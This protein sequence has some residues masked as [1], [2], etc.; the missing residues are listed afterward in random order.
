MKIINNEL[1]FSVSDIVRHFRS[2][3]SAWA[4][5][6]NL[7]QPGTVYVENDMI[8]HSSL[9][10]RSEENEA[11]AKRFLINR[12]DKVKTI[13]N[14]L[15]SLEES[16][17][18]MQEKVDVIVQPTLK[19]DQFTG[20]ADFIILNK[21]VN[22]YE[23]MDAKLA[24]QVK[25]EFLLQVCG[26][27]WM[28]E[29]FNEGI[30]ESGYFFLGDERSES[31]KINEYYRFFIDLK[32][33]FL[34]T[35]ENYSLDVHPKPRKWEVFEEFNDA[36]ETFWK[37]NSSLELIADVSSRQIQVLEKEGINSITEVPEVIEKSF[38]K[39][40]TESLDKIKRQ[41]SAQLQS[42]EDNTHIELLNG[43]ESIHFLHKLLPDESEGDVYFDLE[44]FPFYDF[45]K[46][47]T[48]EYLYGVAYKDENSD[49]IF[50]DD[51]WAEDEFEEK[52]IF[53][54]FINWMQE[55]I[56]KYPDLKIY[57]YA[58]YEITSLR[59]SAKKHA[60]YE[61]IVEDWIVTGRF[62]DLYTVIRKCFLI[63]K[64]SYS[65]KRVEEVAGFKRELDLKSGFDSIFYF[66]RYLDS[67]DPEIKE[68]ILTYNKDDCF[69]TE[70]V[71]TWLRNFKKVYP[72][73]IDF[74]EEDLQKSKEE[75]KD[76][77][78]KHPGLSNKEYAE[79]LWNDPKKWRRV[80]PLIREI[81]IQ[82]IHDLIHDMKQV[83]LNEEV[84]N[85]ISTMLG[86]Y[87]REQLVGL[88][89]KFNLKTMTLEDKVNNS[90]TFG[91]LRLEA[92]EIDKEGK[93]LLTYSC[94]DNT[95][96]KVDIKDELILQH[97]TIEQFVDQEV[98]YKV[99]EI[100][101]DF[102]GLLTLKIQEG[103]KGEDPKE[104]ADYDNCSG[105]INPMPSHF[106][107]VSLSPFNALKNICL[108]Y[109]ET[110]KLP[111]LTE[112][113]LNI[114]PEIHFDTAEKIEDSY[115]KIF[116]ITKNM[117]NTFLPIQGPPG[118]G[119]S[120]ILG[121]VI[122]KLS[123]EGFKVAIASNSYAA[124]FNLVKKVLP[125]LDTEVITFLDFKDKSIKD[126]IKQ[127]PQINIPKSDDASVGENIVATTT[128][129]ICH[130]R[131]W[132][133]N[134]FDYLIIDEVGQ[135]PLVTTIATTL[136]TK[137]LILIGDPNQLPQVKKG[138][139][140]N[141][142]NQSTF[143]YLINETNVIDKDK[144]V[145]LDKTFRLHPEIN[146]F[147][148]NYFY[149]N[150]LSFDKK[151]ELRYLSHEDNSLKKTGIQFVEVNHTGNTLASSEEIKEIKELVDKL[152]NS[153][154]VNDGVERKITKDDI[155]IVAPYNLQVYEL[156]KKLGNNFKIGTI[157][158][159]QGQEA[160]IVIVSFA[161]SS[162]EDAPRGIEFILNFN[163]INVAISRAQCLTL[164]VGSPYLTNLFYQNVNSIKLTNLHRV[165]MG[166][167]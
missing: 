132:D 15:N 16:K 110:G 10:K 60:L 78:K 87:N 26:Y 96:K 50:K 164:I 21:D 163:R 44:G 140:P 142:N 131:Y 97:P 30:P 53:S 99:K 80:L 12:F 68:E 46:S 76:Y 101:D 36:A 55:R 75:K 154:F 102:D 160:P 165:L 51:L 81:E 48:L 59:N 4:T 115:E 105:Y 72:Y 5:W 108:D 63:G 139:Q 52:I 138:T 17:K 3:Y 85:F 20:R 31:F 1:Q 124:V 127:I 104:I 151:N 9:L 136:S 11:D 98:T 82:E 117:N 129:K 88:W 86:Y 103:W 120:T 27:T 126:E 133:E 33:E 114:Q 73:D 18:L 93:R 158:K 22:M 90:S 42:T 2:P 8:Q 79:I 7:Q 100:A 24:K 61:D 34:D 84:Q 167:N 32:D 146:N 143:E 128:N 148:S 161:A 38:P 94:H 144:G 47:D 71:C 162:S 37:E 54:K 112:Q 92:T 156:R 145:F 134:K 57:H 45:R 65:L 56:S 41:A 118:T 113:I 19:R 111:Q 49:L 29:K 121:E 147:I 40:A 25:P 35:V 125:H 116:E 119:K 39:L 149:N 123:K 58:H 69:A 137:N 14:P 89:E 13:S 155:L 28:L 66:E 23:V 135:V 130:Q 70:V 106:S 6:A 95:F 157:D 150:S 153:S 67:R 152:L 83:K 77:I 166:S 74:I 122:A 91:L 109:I 64:D 141:K 43:D 62:V 159:F 107:G